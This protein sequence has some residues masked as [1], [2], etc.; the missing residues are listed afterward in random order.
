MTQHI[1]NNSS[2]FIYKKIGIWSCLPAA[3]VKMSNMYL[4][5]SVNIIEDH[6]AAKVK[7][8]K[9]RYDLCIMTVKRH[10]IY[11]SRI[12]PPGQSLQCT[13]PSLCILWLCIWLARFHIWFGGLFALMAYRAQTSAP[14][15]RPAILDCYWMEG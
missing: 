7:D 5:S 11:Q 15:L 8:I 4:G 2:Y 13:I 3:S 9:I 14:P 10:S 1:V 6:A 12:N